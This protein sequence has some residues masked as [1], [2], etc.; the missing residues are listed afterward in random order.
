MIAS[1]DMRN[2]EAGTAASRIGLTSSTFPEVQ[3][4]SQGSNSQTGV[5]TK[6]V[7]LRTA[8][9]WY[10]LRTTYGREKKAYDYIIK[11]NGTAFYPTVSTVKVV[12][13]KRKTVE[14]SRLPNI[15]FA[16]GTEDEIKAFVYDNVNLPFLRFYYARHRE[17]TVIVK[18]PL[19][20]P[21][22]Q[23]ESLRIIC[24]SETE[25]IIITSESIEKFKSGQLVRI[26]GGAFA[27]VEGRVAR[28]CGQQRVA[29]IVDG[30]L[31][32]VTAYVPSGFLERM[33]ESYQYI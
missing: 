21:D 18:E 24:A 32:A 2:S 22:S 30:L 10:V 8:S 25:D 31:T 29:V 13:G 3:V 27:G 20:I 6:N 1:D 26:M 19:I 28:Y 11:N 9:H 16:Y 7:F 5:S 14:E 15:F 33:G 23:M 12:N 4:P 17:G